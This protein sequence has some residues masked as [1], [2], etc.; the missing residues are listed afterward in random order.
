MYRLFAP[1]VLLSI[2][3]A[4]AAQDGDA[5]G[6]SPT[7]STLS[8]QVQGTVRS[9][10][11][12]SNKPV[13]TFLGIPF[14]TPPV[15][16]LRFRPPEPVAPWE[17]VMDATEFGP[18][19]PQD[20]ALVRSL[21][22][23]IPLVVPSDIVSEDCLVLNVMTTSLN[24]SAALPVMVWI[25]GGGLQSGTGSRY[26][27]TALAA[28]QDVVVVTLHYRL[29][30]LGFLS[31]GDDN[32]PGNY[33]LLDQVE[34]LRWIKSNIRSFGGDPD[35][36]TI[37]GE[38]AGGQS[39]SYLV[40]SPLANGLFHRAISQS[41]TAL[42]QNTPTTTKSLAAATVQ[43]EEVGCGNLHDVKAM[44][45]CLRQKP[46]QD[47]VDSVPGVARKL[48]VKPFPPVVD[49]HFLQDPPMVVLHKGQFSKVP[50]LLGVNNHEFGYLL[51]SILLPGFGNGIPQ[52][53]LAAIVKNLLLLI[54]QADIDDEMV[55][56]VLE[57]YQDPDT[58]AD[59]MAVQMML[60]HI[61]SD[62]VWLLPTV[63][64]ANNHAAQCA[65]VYL[66]ENQHRPA[67]IAK[68]A[69]VGSDHGD[70][71]FMVTGMPYLG[72]DGPTYP[73]KPLFFSEEDKQFSLDMMAYWANFARTGNPSDFTG[74]PSVRPNLT[75]WPS[76][77]PDNPAYLKLAVTSSAEVG[78]KD[79]HVRFWYDILHNQPPFEVP[80]DITGKDE[81]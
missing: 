25:H 70:D 73:S 24:S 67:A 16:D 48:G 1:V 45:S 46:F 51:P 69:W 62:S 72:E 17:G 49:K 6:H 57:E 4:A 77:T 56:S 35:C 28:Y 47:I 40:L 53:A 78:L 68:P 41:G 80:K 42:G 63:V 44:M 36:V 29:G 2:V 50:Y 11:A 65:H 19:C 10:P 3:R 43:A 79:N 81:L 39:V 58:E 75:V 61:L 7:V 76:Y 26:N 13:F 34:A 20:L 60:T 14:A 22:D 71:L 8:G 59:P 38:S 23:F 30:A 31:T 15:G 66:Y 12:I 55:A 5:R 54:A 21:Y 27:F 37:F 74:S 33:G 9:A 32:A 64:V 52:D 18:N